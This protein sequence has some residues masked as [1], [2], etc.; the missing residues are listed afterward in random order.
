MTRRIYFWMAFAAT[1]GGTA[2]HS[3]PPVAGHDYV[4]Q[5]QVAT[6]TRTQLSGGNFSLS[7]AVPP[8]TFPQGEGYVLT[9]AT[10]GCS[11]NRGSGGCGCLCSDGIFSDGFET[12]DT[13]AWTVP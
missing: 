4:L 7:G 8:A 1:L 2:V 13:S 11:A 6:E 5:G 12:G 9:P 10:A 3:R